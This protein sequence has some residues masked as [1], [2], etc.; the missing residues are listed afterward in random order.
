MVTRFTNKL[1]LQYSIEL[2]SSYYICY[3]HQSINPTIKPILCS[4]WSV[5]FPFKPAYQ[6]RAGMVGQY[7]VSQSVKWRYP[8][9]YQPLTSAVSCFKQWW[10]RIKSDSVAV[11]LSPSPCEQQHWK[12]Q[13]IT[14]LK[15]ERGA[16]TGRPQ[17]MKC[18]WAILG[19]GHYGC[20]RRSNP[21]SIVQLF[22]TYPLVLFVNAFA[23]IVRTRKMN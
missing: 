22:C 14:L 12:I 21:E 8:I 23:L 11:L 9:K 1:I 17:G 2:T 18:T 19:N 5:H 6:I 3:N 13:S 10:A 4:P 15:K 20:N 7:T 16:E